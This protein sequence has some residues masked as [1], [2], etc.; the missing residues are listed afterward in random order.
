MSLNYDTSPNGFAIQVGK[1]CK[2]YNQFSTDAASLDTYSAAILNSFQAMTSGSPDIMVEGIATTFAGYK[3]ANVA[4]KAV[5]K[6]LALTRLRDQTTVLDEIGSITDGAD[7]IFQKLIKQMIADSKTFQKNTVTLGSV[8]AGA[9][10]VGNGTVLTSLLLDGYSSPGAG[11]AGTYPSCQS[12]RGVTS[13]LCVA[14]ETMRLA[15]AADSYSDRTGEGA[16]SVSW[17]GRLPD[18][19]DG[20]GTEG[21]G[22]MGTIQPTHTP[23]LNVISNADFETFTTTDNPD[24]WTI[25]TGTAGTHIVEEPTTADVYHGSKAIRFVGDGAL[26]SIELR[27]AISPSTL[28]ANKLYC[29]T[30]RL[31]ASATIPAG[32]LTIQLRGTGY[33]PGAT[34]KITVAHGS[35]PTTYTLKNFFVILPA[36]I[37]SDFGL[38]ILWNGTPTA[39][40][41]LWIDDISL[42]PANYG[43]GVAIAV[44]RGS[45]PFVRGDS[46]SFTVAN[47]NA[48]VFQTFFRKTFGY[49][50]PSSGAPAIADSLAT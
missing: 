17:V 19:A 21:S 16:E 37:P 38:Q 26:A 35:L 14:S 48:G 10:N 29:F 28:I 3:T 39:A 40:K 23:G 11:A 2:Y 45:T 31:K 50:L 8:T 4:R 30:V 24:S 13:E 5:L 9:G 18:V 42:A 33:T 25:Y 32:D 47:D 6:S 34:E 44:V 41:T 22:D 27:Q 46:F 49:Q 36:V 1:C 15:I 7:E 43:G 12:Y 20:V